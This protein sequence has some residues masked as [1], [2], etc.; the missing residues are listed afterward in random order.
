MAQ[1]EPLPTK[2]SEMSPLGQKIL[3]HW[4]EHWPKY[5]ALLVAK[6]QLHQ[7][8]EEAAVQHA[9]IKSSPASTNPELGDDQA[10]EIARQDWMKG[11]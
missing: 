2:L 1:N 6:G 3:K 10:E 8:A 5:T 4:R 11:E 7:R 9:D